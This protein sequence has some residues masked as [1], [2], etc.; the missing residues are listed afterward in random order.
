MRRQLDRFTVV[1]LLVFLSGCLAPER[2]D[3]YFDKVIEDSRFVPGSPDPVRPPHPLFQKI[4][5]APIVNMPETITY[6]MNHVISRAEFRTLI[7]LALRRANLMSPSVDAATHRLIVEVEKVDLP[8]EFK[9]RQT[10]KVRTRIVLK[11][12]GKLGSALSFDRL[13]NSNG[14]T[15]TNPGASTGPARIAIHS[16]PL[17]I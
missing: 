14:A 4:V 3:R 15:S 5:F 9:Y 12:T 16:I 8:F 17:N 13:S 2:L 7:D 11:P 10:S 1:L 6:Y